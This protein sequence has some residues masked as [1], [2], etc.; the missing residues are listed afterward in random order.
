[1]VFKKKIIFSYLYINI[2]IIIF[3][4]IIDF[5]YCFRVAVVGQAFE[6]VAKETEPWFGTKYKIEKIPPSTIEVSYE[7]SV[8][9]SFL[10][11]GVFVLVVS[12]TFI[13]IILYILSL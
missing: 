8:V 9:Y 13:F 6:N 7:S 2:I 11:G 5:I 3:Y 1:M 10:C 4:I 12:N